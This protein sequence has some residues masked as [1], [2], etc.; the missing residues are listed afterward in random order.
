MQDWLRQLHA[1][2]DHRRAMH[3]D[4]QLHPVDR[5]DRLVTRGGRTLL[6][7][8]SNDYLALATHPALRDAVIEAARSHGVGAGASRLV[9]GDLLIHHEVE[10]RFAAFKHAQAALITPTGYAANLAAVTA[11]AGEGD[12]LCADKLNHASLVDA[13]R[14]SGATLRIYPHLN[15]DKLERLL[16]RSGEARRRLIVTDAV[17]SMDGDCADLPR[18]CELR[19]RYD[20]IL[21][22]DEAHATGVLGESGAGLAEHQGMAGRIDVT[23][24][25]AGKALGG[26]GGI[27]TGSRLIIETLVSAARTFI[28]TTA[29]PPTQVA[30]IGAALDVVAA[31][32]QRRM[33][34]RRLS[35]RLR[36]RLISKGWPIAMDPTPIVPLVVGTAEA[37]IGLSSRLEAA[38]YL[39]PAIR[40]PTVPTGAAR[41]RVSL[42]ADMSDGDIDG[43]VDILPASDK[44]D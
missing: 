12:V 23:V 10:A 41:L 34:L 6:N 7:F 22:V 4:R 1:D 32:P 26:L 24:S 39:V 11:L 2:E 33:H 43:L 21:I 35:D 29:P 37:A 15:L 8:A 9:T 40:P 16:A 14:L 3:L 27:V 18:L 19:D 13:A 30:A 17:F 44:L 25:T 28:Y 36:E 38:G 42:R 20:A 31:E 5:C